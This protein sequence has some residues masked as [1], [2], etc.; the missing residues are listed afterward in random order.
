M[1]GYTQLNL[2]KT[3][4]FKWGKYAFEKYMRMLNLNADEDVTGTINNKL[5]SEHS[6][7]I[8]YC[9]LSMNCF[10]KQQEPDFSFE[11]C[12]EWDETMKPE[13]QI[14]IN[15]AV[16][17]SGWFSEFKDS[18]KKKEE[19]LKELLQESGG[20]SGRKKSSSLAV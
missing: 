4:G 7:I 15:E 1:N 3:R 13:E 18:L 8:L 20:K 17:S 9:G 19:E 10:V 14:K 11:D 16:E 2:D 12:V 6:A 5:S